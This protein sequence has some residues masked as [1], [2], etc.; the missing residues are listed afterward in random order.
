MKQVK[1]TNKSEDNNKEFNELKTRVLTL[2]RL[3]S[4][5]TEQIAK[6]DKSSKFKDGEN[7]NLQDEIHVSINNEPSIL[8]CD[9]C[10]KADK[11][12][13]DLKLHKEVHI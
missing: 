1:E 13:N 7:I 8:C 10:D 2:E 9:E 5:L 12:I 3:F 6:Q 11:S 4:N